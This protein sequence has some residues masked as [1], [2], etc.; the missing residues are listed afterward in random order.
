MMLVWRQVKA[1]RQRG[2][3]LLEVLVGGVMAASVLGLLM[4]TMMNARNMRVRSSRKAT[5]GS[6]VAQLTEKARS[7]QYDDSTDSL[8]VNAITGGAGSPYTVTLKGSYDV[9]VGV[10]AGTENSPTG[11]TL[12]YKDVTIAVSFV[13]PGGLLDDVVGATRIY[14]D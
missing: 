8:T 2:Y 11:E 7:L 1:T 4:V 9:T 3:L 14:E 10:T 13:A 12:N 6:I 5:A